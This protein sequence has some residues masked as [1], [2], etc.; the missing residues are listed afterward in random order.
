MRQN[1]NNLAVTPPP[2]IHKILIIN[3]AFIGDVILSTPVARALRETYPQAVIDMLVVPVTA[4]IAELNPYI[5]TVHVYDKKGRHRNWRYAFQLVKK[6]RTIQ[7]D[8]VVCTNFALRGAILAWLIGAPYRAGYDA[9][10]G[11][12]FL[13]H[14]ASARR[15]V[16]RH[17]AENYLDVVKPLGISTSDTSLRL[18]IAEEDRLA[19]KQQVVRSPGKPLVLI[20]P[21]GSYKRKSWTQDGYRRLIRELAPFVDIGLIGGQ[22][23][24]AYLGELNRM[25]GNLAQVYGGVFDLRQLAAFINAANLLISV[26]TAPLHIAQAVGTPVIVLFGPTDPAVWGPRGEKD[27]VF[28]SKVHCAPCWGKSADCDHRCMVAI[29]PDDVVRKAKEMLMLG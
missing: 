17:E 21:A 9:Q 8:M 29:E 7:Y 5:N 2:D 1:V 24:K 28:Y 16:I 3:L 11:K 26:D 13:T 20:C 19:I 10:H 12:W 22:A 4:G 27:V 18:T 15:T 23:E 14:A 6:L 25:S